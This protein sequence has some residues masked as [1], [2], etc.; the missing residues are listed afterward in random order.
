[1]ADLA[2]TNNDMS[3][4]LAGTGIGTVFVDLRLCVLGFTPAAALLINLIPADVGRP[5]AHFS[6][7]LVGYDRLDADLREVLSTLEHKAID[8]HTLDGLDYTMR[9]QPYRTLNNIVE[10][11]VITFVDITELKQSEAALRRL[12]TELQRLAVVVRDADDALTVHDLDGRTLAWNP[13]A[14][15]LYGWTEEQA[16]QMNLRDRIPA[17]LCEPELAGLAERSLAADLLPLHTQRLTRDGALLEV[18]IISSALVD[19]HAKVYAIAT[20]ERTAG[21]VSP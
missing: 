18:A 3:N 14:V 19:E 4:L 21:R 11:V 5:L 15:R 1:M 2:R 13:A 20:T 12:A 16:L 8:V 7:R 10:G 17:A 6:A 9:I